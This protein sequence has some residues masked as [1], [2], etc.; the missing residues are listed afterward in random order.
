MQEEVS[1][2]AL[3]DVIAAAVNGSDGCLFCFGHAN[4]GKTRSM[5][6][7]DRCAK[8]M[9]AIPAAVAWLYRAIKASSKALSL[10]FYVDC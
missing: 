9:G 6:G 2:A 8:D 10:T 4:L 1:S 7:G 5:L 3:G